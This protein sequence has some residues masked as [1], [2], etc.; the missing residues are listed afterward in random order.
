MIRRLLSIA[1]VASVCAV[2]LEA[3]VVGA[4]TSPTVAGA[5]VSKGG[6]IDVTRKSA[7]IVALASNRFTCESCAQAVIPRIKAL[8]GISKISFGPLVGSSKNGPLVNGLVGVLTVS[9]DPAKTQPIAIAQAA[10]RGLEADP[11]NRALV[12]VVERTHE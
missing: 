8:P 5:A 7:G 11:H 10:K 2:G 9:F 3:S 4:S 1:T 12:S 6:E